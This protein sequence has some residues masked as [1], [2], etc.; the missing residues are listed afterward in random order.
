MKSFAV[1]IA[2][3][4][5]SVAPA[6]AACDLATA[7]A[8]KGEKKFAL[9]KACHSVTE[10]ANKVGPHL[11]GVIDRPVA[12]IAD[13]VYSDAMKAFGATGAKWDIATLDT[14]LTKP[15]LLVPNTKMVFAGFPKEDDRC[16]VIKFLSGKPAL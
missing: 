10:K 16:N 8:A 11:D 3:F 7:D 9:C 13:F 1:V 2:V 5:M 15:K 4:A 6:Y 14:Y 12:S